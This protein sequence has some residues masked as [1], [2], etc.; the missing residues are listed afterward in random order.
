MTGLHVSVLLFVSIA[1]SSASTARE[2]FA[3]KIDGY[4]KPA[5]EILAGLMVPY[6]IG[7]IDEAGTFTIALNDEVISKVQDAIEQENQDSDEWTTRLITTG[8][9]FN[10]SDD[11][12]EVTNT[13]LPVIKLSTFGSYMIG[14]LEEQVEHGYFMATS[15]PAFAQAFSAMGQAD[16]EEGYYLDWFYF[17]EPFSVSGSCDVETYAM[18]QQDLY[19]QTTS[20]D[21]DFE[22]G[23][24]L[25]KYAVTEVFEDPDGTDMPMNIRYTSLDSVPEDVQYYLFE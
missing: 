14:D 5:A 13:E 8:R 12:V 15:S 6:Q 9:I 2:T 22:A 20:Y 4:D 18:N 19:V 25:V 24:T 11:T 7:V 16:A 10:C 23:W 1:A 17:E 21:L 3:G